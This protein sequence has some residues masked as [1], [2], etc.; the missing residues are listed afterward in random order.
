MLVA[1]RS[2]GPLVPLSP[3]A[4]MVEVPEPELIASLEDDVAVDSNGIV[5]MASSPPFS[6]APVELPLHTSTVWRDS[7][8]EPYI[9][10]CEITDLL[11]LSGSELLL[12]LVPLLL[13]L[14]LLS[15]LTRRS[16]P[17]LM[18]VSC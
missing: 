14:L 2:G 17:E 6:A 9:C 4:V 10:V 15:P 8:P 1:V 5:I 12:L 3:F 13:P 16:F 11:P 7:F 18:L